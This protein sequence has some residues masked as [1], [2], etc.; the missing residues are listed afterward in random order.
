MAADLQ[1]GG[2]VGDAEVDPREGVE[3][4]ARGAVRI[5]IDAVV[6]AVADVAGAVARR[7]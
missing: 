2:R 1:V 3:D 7:Q 5:A 4:F 6:V